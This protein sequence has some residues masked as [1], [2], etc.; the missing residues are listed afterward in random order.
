LVPGPARHIRVRQVA[1]TIY[2][3]GHNLRRS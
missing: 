3:L 1:S 2:V